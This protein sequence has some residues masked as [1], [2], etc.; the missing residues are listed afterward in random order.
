MKNQPLNLKYNKYHL[1]CYPISERLST[2]ALNVWSPVLRAT[3]APN[4]LPV[5]IGALPLISTAPIYTT[6]GIPTRA[7]AAAGYSMLPAPVSATTL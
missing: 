4:C 3:S 5:H 6:Q 2:A 1:G 7:H